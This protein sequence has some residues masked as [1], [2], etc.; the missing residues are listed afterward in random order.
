MKRF[1]VFMCS[2]CHRFTLA[3]VGQKR[4][5]CSYCGSFIDI[6]KAQ[7]ALF[8]TPEQAT[9]AVKE[10][11][12]R[13]DDEFHKAVERSR[14]KI[15]KLVPEERIKVSDLVMEDG[16]VLPT[17][18]SQ[19]LMTLLEREA[20][21]KSCTL[22][23]IETLC[24]EYQLDWQWV[25]SQ[26]NKMANGGVLIFPRPWAVKLVK[27]SEEKDTDTG[28]SIDVSKEVVRLLHKRGEAMI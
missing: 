18:K 21:D 2:K 20:K 6:K 12:A 19:R 16:E 8:D 7:K 27:L 24:D 4:R 15:L 11:N 3:P 14:E 28:K 26:L 22:D 9:A 13:K 1:F 25:E 10:Y 5:R 23:R 17:G